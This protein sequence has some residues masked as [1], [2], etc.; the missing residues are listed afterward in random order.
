MGDVHLL[1]W[2]LAHAFR[3][4]LPSETGDQSL[5]RKLSIQRAAL[6]HRNTKCIHARHVFLKERMEAM[7]LVNKQRIGTSAALQN[8]CQQRTKDLY[9]RQAL[10]I[11]AQKERN[12]T[13]LE[14]LQM[15]ATDGADDET[16]ST[17]CVLSRAALT[18]EDLCV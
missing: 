2:A 9:K 6:M 17:T 18:E 11:R 3:Q 1:S 15:R 16:S 10:L 12:S 8:Q 5:M 13:Q 7:A 4:L 14:I